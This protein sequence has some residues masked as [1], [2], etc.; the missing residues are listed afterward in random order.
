MD[1]SILPEVIAP[2]N[3]VATNPSVMEV[4]SPLLCPITLHVISSDFQT[5]ERMIL[6]R[7]LEHWNAGAIGTLVY[8]L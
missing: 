7:T 2:T 5:M 1:R 4:D 3:L 8:C 6:C